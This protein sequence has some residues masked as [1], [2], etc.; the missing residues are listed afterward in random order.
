MADEKDRSGQ[1]QQ[2]QERGFEQ[3]GGQQGLPRQD[4]QRQAQNP[5]QQPRPTWGEQTPDLDRQR[6]EGG[7][8]TSSDSDG[9][10]QGQSERGFGRQ[11][12]NPD[13]AQRATGERQQGG[14]GQSYQTDKTGQH[15][16]R[17]R[18]GGQDS[19]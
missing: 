12:G 15:T 13:P 19:H 14:G 2:H 16:G 17:Q 3:P 5:T 4:E 11:P 1:K 6:A 10:Q 8:G 9:Q 18:N 7:G